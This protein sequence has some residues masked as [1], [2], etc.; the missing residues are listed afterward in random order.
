MPEKKNQVG[1]SCRSQVTML[2][3]LR[4]V[5][6]EGDKRVSPAAI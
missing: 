4:E 5:L 2:H 3:R 1:K 6:H